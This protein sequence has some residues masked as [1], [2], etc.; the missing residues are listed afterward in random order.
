MKT[1]ST[2]MKAL[3]QQLDTKYNFENTKYNLFP[4]NVTA[5]AIFSEALLRKLKTEKHCDLTGGG[6]PSL[7]WSLGP[8][9]VVLGQST[10]GSMFITTYIKIRRGKQTEIDESYVDDEGRDMMS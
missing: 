6:C 7:C 2:M 5:A 8:L 3:L 9:Y 10:E 4:I 1:G